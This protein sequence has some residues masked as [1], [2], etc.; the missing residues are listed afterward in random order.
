MPSDGRTYITVH[1]GMPEHPKVDALSDKAFRVLV[2]LWCWCSRN[3]TDGVVKAPTWAKR[4]P[5]KVGQELIAAGLVDVLDSG[6]VYMHD[7][8]EHQRSRAQVEELKA[9][10][11]DAGSKGGRAKADRVASARASARATAQQT[12]SNDV[13]DTETDTEP[14]PSGEGTSAVAVAPA[15]TDRPDVEALCSLLADL[16]EANGARRPA[17]TKRWKDAARLL[18]DKDGYTVEQVEWIARWA[19][20]HE[21]WRANVLS[22]PTLREKFDQLKLQA[23]AGRTANGRRTPADEAA[24]TIALGERMQAELEQHRIGA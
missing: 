18:L 21:F 6:D 23:L 13:P 22:M 4:A 3:L 9:K 24:A 7:Y 10:R 8:L 14:S 17:V 12:G 11:R 20:S 1:D 16:V 5:G 15:D 2:G 19:T